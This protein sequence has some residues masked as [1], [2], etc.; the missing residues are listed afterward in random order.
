MYGEE[1][2]TLSPVEMQAR[3]SVI[4]FLQERMEVDQIRGWQPGQLADQFRL[5]IRDFLRSL[6]LD[7]LS[8]EQKKAIFDGAK[9]VFDNIV[10]PLD[11]PYVPEFAEAMLENWVWAG[12]ESFLKAK[13]GL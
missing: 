8:P 10:R 2:L 5:A 9:W 4:E 13:L 7:N 12:V 1:N 11:I 3:R 6:N